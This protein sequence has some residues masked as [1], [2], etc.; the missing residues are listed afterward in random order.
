MPPLTL[1]CRLCK[2]D[3]LLY[4]PYTEDIE[5]RKI[6]ACPTCHIQVM[7]THGQAKISAMIWGAP[8]NHKEKLL[9]AYNISLQNKLNP[10]CETC[11]SFAKCVTVGV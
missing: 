9:N 1:N 11:P 3:Y 4:C 10:T 8:Y 2:Q 7:L 5:V 6:G